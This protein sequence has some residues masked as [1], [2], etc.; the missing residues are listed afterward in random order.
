MASF[1]FVAVEED[2]P[3]PKWQGR[4]GRCATP[5]LVWI[6]R[7]D[8]ARRPSL[9]D[10]RAALA[11]HMP[12][13]LPVYG[14]LCDLVGPDETA[15]RLLSQWNP[16]PLFAGCSVMVAPGTEPALIRNYDFSPDFFEGTIL[17]SRWTGGQGAV[18]ALSE[19]LSGVL[20]G[21][22]EAGLAVALTFGGRPVAGEGF[23][24]PIILRHVLETCAD[25]P[26]AVE[27]L[28]RIPCAFA[29]NV[30]LLDRA[31]RHSVAWL[32]PDRPA[33]F[34]ALPFTTNH[35]RT[36]EWLD[37][38]RFS[39]TVERAAHLADLRTQGT[40]PEQ[41]VAQFH[42]PPLF[43][44]DYARGLGTLY[45]AAYYPASGRVDF[46]WPGQPPLS[47]SFAAFTETSR[48]VD[49]RQDPA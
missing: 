5:Y 40:A 45:T 14:R 24:I 30:L 44:T 15:R 46:L 43:R 31:G 21:M 2:Q 22:N 4:F 13:M 34:A 1:D 3:G 47:Q 26:A 20:D 9:G 35:Q 33:E 39:Q 6:A 23:S 29:Q 28:R 41:L 49:F 17:K 48:T 42:R 25:V 19:G 36:V 7:E 8:P 37:S 12:Q 27:V 32:G 10:C 16:P 38:A 18:I 11:L